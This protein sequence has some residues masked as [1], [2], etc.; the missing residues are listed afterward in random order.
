MSERYE[1]YKRIVVE[2]KK[3]NYQKFV[4]MYNSDRSVI[5]RSNIS[6]TKELGLSVR[7]I[8]S[9]KEKL[10]DATGL[11]YNHSKRMHITPE[12]KK[13]FPLEDGV[14]L[15]LKTHTIIGARVLILSDIHFP[16]HNAEALLLALKYGRAKDIDTV[17]LNGDILDCYQIS[18]FLHDTKK[19]S[20][21]EE[22]LIW[23]SFAAMLRKYFPLANIY[24]KEGNHEARVYKYMMQNAAEMADLMDFDY[25][26]GFQ[27]FHIHY[28]QNNLFIKLGSLNILHGHEIQGGG[29]NVA[30]SFFLKM[31]DNI[32]F[33]HFHRTQEYIQNDMHKN[34][35]GAWATG[36]LCLDQDY[37][38]LSNS[39]L[40]FAYVES[41]LDG[42]FI[43]ENKKIIKG[44]IV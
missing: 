28:L 38:P 36:C 1:P 25:L 34:I 29:I 30:R 39:N 21:K 5:D 40:G 24:F 33:G 4:D 10:R 7:I 31:G 17:I 41:N 6:L 14:P 27:E 13:E 9:Y 26:M 35:R 42:T 43:V 12:D 20:I 2:S 11:V 3:S 15:T 19:M 23:K 37:N 8:Q 32:L 16:Y 18:R 44:Q 22:I